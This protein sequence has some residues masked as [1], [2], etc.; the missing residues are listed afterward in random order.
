MKS[1]REG[2]AVGRRY[3]IRVQ[4]TIIF[5]LLMLGTIGL[6]WIINNTFLEK[7]Y[8]REKR[9]AL[10]EMYKKVNSAAA[11]NTIDSEEFDEVIEMINMDDDRYCSVILS[12]DKEKIERFQ[13]EVKTKM[14][15][16]NENPYEKFGKW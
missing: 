15:C 3:S 11:N 14:I 10:T 8:L 7:Y 6:C 12:K 1:G 9:I 13:K 4:F 2:K 5:L 16:V